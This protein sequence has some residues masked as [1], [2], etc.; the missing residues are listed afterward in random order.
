V[1]CAYRN[2]TMQNRVSW[3]VGWLVVLLLEA[4]SATTKSGSTAS[5][6][7]FGGDFATSSGAGG[8]LALGGMA[9]GFALTNIAGDSA[10]GG[11]PSMGGGNNAVQCN[12][13]FTGYLLDFTTAQS[14]PNG[15]PPS[16]VD[17]VPFNPNATPP[18]AEVIAGVS[19]VDSPDFEVA[20]PTLHP[21]TASGKQFIN[22]PGMVQMMLGA[23][24][25]PAYAGPA[26][27]TAT[28]TGPTN[29][30]TWFHDT[31]NVNMGKSL[32]LQFEP[33]PANPSDPNAYY[34]DSST[35]GCGA[36]TCPGFFPV[37]DQ[38]LLNEGNAHNY[39]MTL[40]LHLKF[41]Y[42]PGQ[43][44]NFQGDDDV[45][46]FVNN[47][48]ALD[49][50]G[51]HDQSPGSINLDDLGLTAGQIYPLDFFWCERHTT[52]SN[53]RA[54]TSLEVTDCGSQVVK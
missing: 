7:G 12:G 11:E 8:A 22:D 17:G 5:A 40:Q 24:R 19:Y 36:A 9:G 43:N 1:S 39:H 41:K 37:D 18:I 45:W 4:C 20:N 46:V 28:T 35:M 49:L 44:F 47:R 30:Q 33:D 13:L 38:L 23:D 29:F 34:Y 21:A 2:L 15:P 51:I 6:N 25:T 53:F 31:P 52:G 14:D 26:G 27:G 32:A 3:S 16:G 48:L 50:G 54:E 10:S 42:K